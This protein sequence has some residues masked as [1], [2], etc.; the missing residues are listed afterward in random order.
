MAIKKDRIIL[1]TNLLISFLLTNRHDLLYD[2]LSNGRAVVIFDDILL[3]EFVQVNAR[4]KFKKYFSKGDIES[5][6]ISLSRFAQIV[7]V[8]SKVN[9][10]RDPKDD[11]Y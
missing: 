5:I 6:L 9:I 4:P 3:D 1:D 10:C 11:F 2:L 7:Q 8:K